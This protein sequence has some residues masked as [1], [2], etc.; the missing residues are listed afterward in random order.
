[1]LLKAGAGSGSGNG[2]SIVIQPGSGASNG[3][4]Q[5]KNS[6]GTPMVTVSE[7]D[8]GLASSSGTVTLS[9]SGLVQLS[10][11]ASSVKLESS[12]HLSLVTAGGSF[13]TSSILLQPG[14]ASSNNGGSVSVLGGSSDTQGGSVYLEQGQDTSGSNDGQIHIGRFGSPTRGFVFAT[15]PLNNGGSGRFAAVSS[16]ISVQSCATSAAIDLSSFFPSWTTPT[17]SDVLFAVPAFAHDTSS[18]PLS[19]SVAFSSGTSFT[20]T[21]C[22]HGS[23]TLS[24]HTGTTGSIHIFGV[25]A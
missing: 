8:L 10:S 16:P 5:L 1:V 7:S 2:G 24:T 25:L 19:V 22:N 13:A 9:G 23:T 17:A 3:V 14:T 21:F 18:S 12:G 20:F 15:I 11:S 4:V 6:G